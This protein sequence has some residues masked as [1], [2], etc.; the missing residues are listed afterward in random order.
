MALTLDPTLTVTLTLLDETG[1]HSKMRVHL[2]AT[3]TAANAQTRAAALAA[4]VAA[5]TGCTVPSYTI[6]YEAED[7]TPGIPAAGSRVEHKG[8]FIFQRANGQSSRLEIP[9]ILPEKVQSDG[10]IDLSDT[11]VAAFVAEIVG[12]GYT[13]PDNSDIG[14]ASAAYEAFTGST[15][16]QLPTR[17]FLQS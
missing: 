14:S 10:A 8:R 2:P 12:N 17:R 3:T 9:S 11:D 13:G 6:S 7:P 15:R 1:S 4:A 16:N 5:N